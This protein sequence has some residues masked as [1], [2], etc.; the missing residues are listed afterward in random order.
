MRPRVDYGGIARL[1]V[2][3]DGENFLAFDQHVGLGEV[4]DGRI[5]RHHRAAADE[6]APAGAAGVSGHI[7]VKVG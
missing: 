2:R 7:V 6:I 1:D 3:S 5:H 4:A